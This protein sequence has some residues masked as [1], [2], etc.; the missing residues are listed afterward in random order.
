MKPLLLTILIFLLCFSAPAQDHQSKED[1]KMQ[2]GEPYWQ[3]GHKDISV[4]YFAEP[5][6]MFIYFEGDKVVEIRVQTGDSC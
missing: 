4:W 5:Y 6:R 1:I 3:G 2:Y